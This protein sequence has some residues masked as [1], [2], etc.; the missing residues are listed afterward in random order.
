[1]NIKSYIKSLEFDKVRIY[2]RANKNLETIYLDIGE[3]AKLIEVETG[4]ELPN[5]IME[6]ET[7]N[8]TFELVKEISDQTFINS[9]LHTER[10]NFFPNRKQTI[11][12]SAIVFLKDDLIVN[13]LNISLKEIVSREK[14]NYAV[15]ISD[16]FVRIVANV[17]KN[18]GFEIF[19]N[20]LP[21]SLSIME[22][23]RNYVFPFELYKNPVFDSF[24]ARV[25]SGLFAINW[26]HAK[27]EIAPKYGRVEIGQI[28]KAKYI[29]DNRSVTRRLLLDKF[30]NEYIKWKS[31][32]ELPEL[33]A[34]EQLYHLVVLA[35]IRIENDEQHSVQL[36]FRTW[37][38]EHGQFVRY[39][40]KD[41]I[42]FE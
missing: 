29:E 9:I 22:Q 24:E 30:W 1:M 13:Y 7:I 37:D 11:F 6:Q 17:L 35:S 36:F 31:E 38:E 33:S 32:Y 41:N 10:S 20:Y 28:R 19:K 25:N 8:P 3:S 5:G 21:P 42:E 16:E 14:S 23:W 27:L 12:D 4:N 39:I 18:E 15:D 34:K 40:D 2:F 26:K